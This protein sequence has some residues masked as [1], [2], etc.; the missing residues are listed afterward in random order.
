[1]LDK[2]SAVFIQNPVSGIQYLPLVNK[3]DKHGSRRRIRRQVAFGLEEL[4]QDAPAFIQADSLGDF[5][6]M[7]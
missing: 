6:L 2:S 7:V 4:P 3:P 5:T 1:M